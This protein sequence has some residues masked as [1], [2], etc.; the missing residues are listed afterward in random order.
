MNHLKV[1]ENIIIKAKS[2]N[3]IKL[4]RKDI[5]YIYYENHHILPKCLGGLNNNENLVLLTAREH[6]LCHKL[7]TYIYPKN[8]KIIHAFHLMTFMNKRKYA[9]SSRDYSYAIEMFRELAIDHHG[10]KNPMYGKKQSKESIQKN[11]NSQPYSS[12]NFPI[13]LK[14]ILSEK[15][16]GENNGMFNKTFYDIWVE[17]FGKEIADQKLEEYKDKK[18]NKIWVKHIILNK[19]KQININ[20]LDAYQLNGWDIGRNKIII[21]KSISN[22][23][24]QKL[25]NKRKEYWIRKKQII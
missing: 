24:K 22:E 4:L 25:S 1:Y 18:R 9:I 11:K 21:R 10:S 16:K 23:T 15:S 12:E 6:F 20:E 2:E 13:W 3:R 14:E 17:K 19:S 7:L 8:K 5:D